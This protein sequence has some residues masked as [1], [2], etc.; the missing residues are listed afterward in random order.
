MD[1]PPLLFQAPLRTVVWIQVWGRG[2]GTMRKGTWGGGGTYVGTYKVCE[3]RQ[4]AA[5]RCQPTAPRCQ[6]AEPV[7][8]IERP[9][10]R[11]GP[12]PRSQPIIY[13]HAATCQ[14]ACLTHFFSAERVGLGLGFCVTPPGGASSVVL[15]SPEPEC[16]SFSAPE[17]HTVTL[18]HGRRY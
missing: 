18:A 16:D 17:F 5:P 9:A 1:E 14:P 10:E 6:L 7:M 8:H 4:P 15:H 12:P 2:S 3:W 13:V 11:R